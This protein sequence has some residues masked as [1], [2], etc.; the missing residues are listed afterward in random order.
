MDVFGAFLLR[1]GYPDVDGLVQLG[2]HSTDLDAYYIGSRSSHAVEKPSM[3][4]VALVDS[5]VEELAARRPSGWLEAADTVLGLSLEQLAFLDGRALPL[6]RRASSRGRRS[7]EQMF[8]LK[9]TAAAPGEE[10]IAPSERPYVT[11]G[12]DVT[13]DLHILWAGS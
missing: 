13:G 9:L 4:S 11:V 12:L 5:F 10:V 8:G 2:S 6:A 7:A 1:T 3:F